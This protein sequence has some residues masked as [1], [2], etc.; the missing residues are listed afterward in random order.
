[1]RMSQRQPAQ[2]V[3]RAFPCARWAEELRPPGHLREPS[4]S[5]ITLTHPGQSVL[6]PPCTLDSP[7]LQ[8]R[9]G[10]WED[11]KAPWAGLD[12]H[13]CAPPPNA[14][15]GLGDVRKSLRVFLSLALTLRA[16]LLPGP[17]P[18]PP[19]TQASKLMAAR[20]QLP[21]AVGRLSQHHPGCG[22]SS[23]LLTAWGSPS[24]R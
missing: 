22:F 16:D 15:M 11:D 19:P 13:P 17:S 2:G 20:I 18:P 8:Q 10:R 9:D 6:G 23:A 4:C 24:S 21:T 14:V 1:M 5:A 12:A 7:R 3:T